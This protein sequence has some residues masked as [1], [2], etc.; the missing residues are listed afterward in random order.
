MSNMTNSQLV[1]YLQ[2]A[3]ADVPTYLAAP[4]CYMDLANIKHLNSEKISLFHHKPL[5]NPLQ[6]AFDAIIQAGQSYRLEH[7]KLGCNELLKAYVSQIT[8]NNQTILTTA[9]TEK[10]DQLVIWCLDYQFIYHSHFWRYL[11]DC[12]RAV[13]HY[14]MEKE[15]FDACLIFIEHLGILGQG[16]VKHGLSTQRL[17]RL[18]RTLE[19]RAEEL[20]WIQGSRQCRQQ[21]YD[22]EIT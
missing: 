19:V 6:L 18:L 12:L 2:K 10:L 21:R 8:K 20:S 9:Y 1:E 7:V 4:S 15:F 16:A 17:Q 11:I 3:L 22:I 13:T 5:D 14:L